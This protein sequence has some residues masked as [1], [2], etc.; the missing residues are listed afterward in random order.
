MIQIND[1]C[2]NDANNLEIDDENLGSQNQLGNRLSD[3]YYHIINNAE[4]NKSRFPLS[5]MPENDSSRD[6]LLSYLALKQ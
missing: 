6:N 5:I 2:G 4:R 1:N 3:L